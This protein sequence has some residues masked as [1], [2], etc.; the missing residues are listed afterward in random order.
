MPAFKDKLPFQILGDLTIKVYRKG[1]DGKDLLEDKTYQPVVKAPNT[2]VNNARYIIGNLLEGNSDYL[3]NK[4]KFGFGGM[5]GSSPRNVAVT[6]T[7]LAS[8]LPSIGGYTGWV[9]LTVTNTAYVWSFTGTLDYNMGNGYNISEEGL[10]TSALLPTGTGLP[11][12]MFALKT[13]QE[14]PKSSEWKFVFTHSISV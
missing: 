2:V 14:M 5:D 6:E 3:L 11:G 12:T 7:N 13:F 1:P 10:F 4:M 8:P 9:P